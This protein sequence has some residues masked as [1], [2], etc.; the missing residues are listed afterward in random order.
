MRPTLVALALALALVHSQGSAPRKVPPTP[1]GALSR[2][3]P[4]TR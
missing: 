2:R 4:P 1:R 3:W